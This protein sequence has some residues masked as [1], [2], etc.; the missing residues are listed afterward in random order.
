ML[1]S[2]Q[3][4]ATTKISAQVSY[5]GA[6]YVARA[7]QTEDGCYQIWEIYVSSPQAEKVFAV[8]LPRRTQMTETR[9][10]QH[11]IGFVFDERI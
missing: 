10:E 11:V 9:I 1:N 2:K 6:R 8:S 5:L 4:I 7:I 3:N